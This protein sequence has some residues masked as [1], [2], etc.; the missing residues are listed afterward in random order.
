LYL[1]DVPERSDALLMPKNAALLTIDRVRPIVWENQNHGLEARATRG[2]ARAP[3]IWEHRCD[4]SQ[5]VVVI[6]LKPKQ[7]V[8]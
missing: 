8:F 1:T 6:R 2:I 4:F 3:E 5:T 7:D